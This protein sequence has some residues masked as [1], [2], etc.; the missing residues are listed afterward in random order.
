LNINRGL[1]VSLLLVAMNS[2]S[3]S[4]SRVM[5]KD[6]IN[7]LD[8]NG[9]G[10]FKVPVFTDL[11][12]VRKM[13]IYF[14]FDE[15]QPASWEPRISG[16]TAEETKQFFIELVMFMKR[17]R[18]YYKHYWEKGDLLIMDNR[19]LIH[20]REQFNDKAIIRRLYRGQTVA[21]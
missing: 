10:V 6:G 8:I 5:L 9:D 18:Y 7:L 2:F 19:R 12:W 20:E 21:I 3:S 4:S 13:L 16:F 14:P 1:L 11:G 15:G 17:D